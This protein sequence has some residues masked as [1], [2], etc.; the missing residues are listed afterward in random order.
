MSRQAKNCRVMNENPSR[1]NAGVKI[2]PQLQAI[3]SLAS[4][5]NFADAVAAANSIADRDVA[6]DAWR[7]LSAM[8]ANLQRWTD[9]ISAIENALKRDPNSHPLRL[10]RALLFEQR[11]DTQTALAELEALAREAPQSPQLLVH[12]A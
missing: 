8:N 4:A 2:A 3:V 7:L 10:T 12:L 1:G 5:G 6:I 11:G 9:A